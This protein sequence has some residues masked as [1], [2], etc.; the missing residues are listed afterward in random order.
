[1]TDKQLIIAYKTTFGSKVGERVLDDLWRFCLEF[2]TTYSP[3][4]TMQSAFNEG[5]RAVALYIRKQVEAT[6]DDQQPEMALT[7]ME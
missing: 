4:D 6:L 3:G 2:R 7:E 1:M 5:A